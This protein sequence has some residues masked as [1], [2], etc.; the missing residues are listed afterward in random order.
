MESV[1]IAVIGGSGLYHMEE[2]TDKTAVALTTPFGSPSADIVIGTLRG[3]RVAFLPRH[4]VGH[5]FTPT[6]VPYRANI[7]AL[8][9]LGVRFI[10]GVNACGSLRDD[11][12]PGHIVMPDQIFDY[13]N[14]RDRSFFDSGMVG[15]VS[16]ADPYTP[17]LIDLAYNAVIEVGGTAHKGGTFLIE[18]GPRFATRAES[19]IFRQWGCSL[20]GMTT[21]PEIFLAREAEIAYVTMAHVTDYDS[22][23]VSE[24]PVTVEQVIQTLHHN[25]HIAQQA[26]AKVIENLDPHA[27]YAAHHALE[28]AI[29]TD[30]RVM[31]AEIRKRLQPLIQKYIPEG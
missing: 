26:I 14:S 16:V 23:H 13:T 12:A 1:S 22:W 25:V 31:P 15:H 27:D 6:T 19:N 8:K 17:E 2:I 18:E 3:K 10:I 30:R 4:G 5:Y 28:N 9:T 20:I 29:M 21:C 7:Y 11:Y 24:K